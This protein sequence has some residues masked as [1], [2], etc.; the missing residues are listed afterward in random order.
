[1]QYLG[2]LSKKF[3]IIYFGDHWDEYLRRRQQIAMRLSKFEGIDKVVYVELPLTIF[4]FFKFL[5]GNSLP[6]VA[7]AWRRILKNGLL[8]K[9]NEVWI[10]T[11]I[12]LLPYMPV[13]IIREINRFCDYW[14]Q[15]LVL[16]FYIKKLKLQDSILWISHPFAAEFIGKLGEKIICYDRTEDFAYMHDCPV[17]V[18]DLTKKND[19]KIIKD[20]D[21]IFVQTKEMQ[22]AISAENANV[23]LVPNAV[24]IQWF[25]DEVINVSDMQGIP[26]PI[27]CYCGNINSR[28]DF[29]LLKYIA[30]THPEWSLV[31]IGHL[32]PGVNEFSLLK[33]LNNVYLLGIKPY[34][35][36]P[37]YFKKTDVC[38]MPHK[39]DKFTESQSPLKLFDYMAAGKPI[40]ST[41]IAG[42]RDYEE[43]VMIGHTKEEFVSLIEKVLINDSEKEVEKRRAFVQQNTWDMRMEDIYKLLTLHSDKHF[44]KY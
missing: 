43:V 9:D 24:D 35:K 18:Q 27:L 22:K 5:L 44:C 32:A 34:R 30:I 25:N 15:L 13:K 31:M 1:M 33:G 7:L 3:N 20:A 39:I 17:A 19:L 14:L 28:I 26:R 36:L 16:K 10:L 29:E 8:C 6:K 42:V 41:K 37:S 21:L 12:T 2:N 11:P 23:F 38:L 40:V 4:S